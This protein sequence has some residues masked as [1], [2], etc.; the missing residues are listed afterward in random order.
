MD[1][2][3]TNFHIFKIQREK[4]LLR[5]FL[6]MVESRLLLLDCNFKDTAI[7]LGHVGLKGMNYGYGNVM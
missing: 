4:L 1:L 3:S 2:F 7:M 6:C 5:I